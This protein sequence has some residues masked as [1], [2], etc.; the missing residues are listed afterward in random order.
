MTA[1][2]AW[3]ISAIQ[4]TP[5]GGAVI[6]LTG[7]HGAPLL[8]SERL[9]EDSATLADEALGAAGA[10]T[11]SQRAAERRDRLDR[12]RISVEEAEKVYART[13]AELN[14]LRNSRIVEELGDN[15]RGLAT[16]LAELD[17]R[18]A[19][20]EQQ[21][22]K[23]A[24]GLRAVVQLMDGAATDARDASLA[25]L[26]DAYAAASRTVQA[27]LDV[28]MADLLEAIHGPLSRVLVLH[29]T[30]TVNLSSLR[31]GYQGDFDTAEY[32]ALKVRVAELETRLA[33]AGLSTEPVAP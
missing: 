5:A 33:E 18:I 10:K 16:R 8:N 19:A 12:L 13:S 23:A 29:H 28:A 24:N 2:N 31:P 17:Q 21:Q 14:V 27:D 22:N 1:N 15:P 11:E 26:G 6:L 3:T 9:F 20:A 32:E 4:G 7:P 25:T 30:V